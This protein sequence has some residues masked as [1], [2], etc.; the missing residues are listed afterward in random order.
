MLYMYIIINPIF[1]I[2]KHIQQETTQKIS[3]LV[4]DNKG[5]LYYFLKNS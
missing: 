4:C 5:K 3:Q 1:E 2:L